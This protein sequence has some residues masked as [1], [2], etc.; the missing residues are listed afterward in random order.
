LE[1]RGSQQKSFILTFS[2]GY[3]L[4]IQEIWCT[5]KI[6]FHPRKSDITL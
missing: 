3:S 4:E 2:E 5:A 1:I 6:I